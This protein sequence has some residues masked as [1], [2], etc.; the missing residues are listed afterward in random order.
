MW[1]IAE[2]H[3]PGRS[4]S[5]RLPGL[6]AHLSQETEIMVKETLEE[7][8]LQ[9]TDKVRYADTDRQ[10]HVNNSVF[11]QFLE[12]ARAE[13]IYSFSPPLVKPDCE[14]VIASLVLDFEIELHWPGTV[15][16]GTRIS[17]IGN[18]SFKLEQAIF[19]DEGRVATARSVIVC[20]DQV[21]RRPSTLPS[22][23]VNLLSSY[24]RS[25][26]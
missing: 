9:S 5:A 7:F 8:P 17:A 25:R 11:C 12:T 1:S 18:T 26:D 16:V 20:V 15:Q 21:T 2:T 3:F 22:A 19:Q 13:L 10:G 23:L 24:G 6:R 4:A 14:F